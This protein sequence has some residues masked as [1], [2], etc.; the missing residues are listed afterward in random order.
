VIHLRDTLLKKSRAMERVV[1]L[2]RNAV[3]DSGSALAKNV[4][5]TYEMNCDRMNKVADELPGDEEAMNLSQIDAK[6]MFK[7]ANNILTQGVSAGLRLAW[8]VAHLD[9]L[10]AVKAT[11]AF[12]ELVATVPNGRNRILM[13]AVAVLGLAGSI[14]AA[15]YLTHKEFFGGADDAPA[16]VLAP[17]QPD[18]L[19]WASVKEGTLW[20]C[21]LAWDSEARPKPVSFLLHCYGEAP[22]ELVLSAQPAP[23]GDMT[24][25]YQSADGPRTVEATDGVFSVPGLALSPA[26]VTADAPGALQAA[27]AGEYRGSCL[28]TLRW[29]EPQRSPRPHDGAVALTLKGAQPGRYRD[30][31]TL[32]TLFLLP[33]C[34]FHRVSLP[35]FAASDAS[36][37]RSLVFILP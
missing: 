32:P 34:S 31:A 36:S 10:E 22:E 29:D 33:S 15:L 8:A 18:S 20:P 4:L 14:V 12:M 24:L 25:I 35:R 37:A 19:A 5:Q 17:L 23:E 27:A 21:I 30:F 11:G 2:L 3:G 26:T 28:L 16:A 9:V 7:N 6:E 1:L 13:T